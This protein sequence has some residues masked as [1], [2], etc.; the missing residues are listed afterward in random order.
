MRNKS[1]ADGI[2]NKNRKNFICVMCL[3]SPMDNYCYN[4]QI[5]LNELTVKF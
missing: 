2:L 3:I 1:D 4:Q 5:S